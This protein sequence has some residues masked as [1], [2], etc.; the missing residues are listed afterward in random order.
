MSPTNVTVVV[1]NSLENANANWAAF[2]T[3]AWSAPSELIDAVLVERTL[4]EFSKFHTRSGAGW[5]RGV[6]A[7]AVCGVLWPSSMRIGALAGSVGDHILTE[8]QRGLSRDAVSALAGVIEQGT[9]VIVVIADPRW[10]VAA[11]GLGT[12]SAQI[13]SVPLKATSQDL[14]AALELDDAED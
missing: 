5:G 2:D 13:A 3:E 4:D 12:V 8:I 11:S 7:S 14:H 6:I 9:Y 10:S 1:H